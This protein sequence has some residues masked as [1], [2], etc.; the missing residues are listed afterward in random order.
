M[1]FVAAIVNS[2]PVTFIG[3]PL[4]I[5]SYS[6]VKFLTSFLD[7]RSIDL[8]RIQINADDPEEWDFINTEFDYE[9]EAMKKQN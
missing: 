5:P 2:G 4:W 1:E 7:N 9:I 3:D 6:W 8:G